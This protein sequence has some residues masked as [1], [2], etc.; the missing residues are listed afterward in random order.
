MENNFRITKEST[1][2]KAGKYIVGLLVW[3][4][5]VGSFAVVFLNDPE[6]RFAQ[7]TVA[8]SVG[9]NEP[10]F[11]M[12]QGGIAENGNS[13][14]PETTSVS[15]LNSDASDTNST[16]NSIPQPFEQEKNAT[17]VNPQVARAQQVK[18]VVAKDEPRSEKKSRG[19][20]PAGWYVQVGAFKSPVNADVYRLKMKTIKFPTELSR[21][22]NQI[23]RV[24]VGPFKSEKE[25]IQTR[26]ILAKEH[27]IKGG[28]IR[29][30][31][32]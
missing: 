2:R 18:P 9:A 30:I 29:N 3:G 31:K 27:K 32:S 7:D 28:I 17:E 5:I 8:H 19:P 26:S 1:S 21:D 15:P 11:V 14:L 22:E 6:Y 4:I 16:P 24:L 23:S 20:V 10:S 13:V 25:A 12:S